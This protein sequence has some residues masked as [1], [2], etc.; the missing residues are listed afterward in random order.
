MSGHRLQTPERLGTRLWVTALVVLPVS[1]GLML[2][3]R[4]VSGE[5]TLSPGS[6]SSAEWAWPHDEEQ[7]AGLS[8]RSEV[9]ALLHEMTRAMNGL[10]LPRRQP[11]Y[12]LAYTLLDIE[13]R[14]VLGQLGAIVQN[15]HDRARSV[16]VEVRVGSAELDNSHVSPELDGF[17][18]RGAGTSVPLG[19][20]PLALKTAV[21]LATDQSYR[22]ASEALEQKRTARANA[23]DYEQRAADFSPQ[24]PLVH[25][26][27]PAVALTETAQLQ[28]VAER[29]SAAFTPYE[30]LHESVVTVAAWRI[31]RTLITSEGS[32]VVSPTR[33]VEVT[34]ECHTQAPDGMPLSHRKTVFG[35]L[36]VEA[37]VQQAQILAQQLTELRHAPL[38]PDYVGPV[39]FAGEA[40]PQIVLELLGQSLI[41]TPVP[42][43][44]PLS[45]RLQRRV[46][47]TSFNVVDDPTLTDEEPV[48]PSMRTPSMM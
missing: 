25:I 13:Q 46:L 17:E 37:L 29:V 28:E 24:P 31:D 38:A 39:L 47:P 7:L 4:P 12:Y 5:E 42:G 22:E 6:D 48:V 41:G 40:A 10:Q 43:E 32:L 27:Q 15:D 35:E 33:V 11:P 36:D 26:A 45:R 18:F 44:G 21:W 19:H 8:E 30:E 1:L 23:V 3:Q 14:L 2:L 16:H 9:N 20:D 34:L